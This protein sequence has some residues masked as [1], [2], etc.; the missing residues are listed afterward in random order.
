MS[1]LASMPKDLGKPS[2]QAERV[3]N[4]DQ[5]LT[6]PGHQ[7]AQEETRCFFVPAWSVFFVFPYPHIG[8]DRNFVRTLCK[9]RGA[10]RLVGG[11]H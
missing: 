1:P 9:A 7:L 6:T 11:R 2:S 3:Q 5:D 8:A 4:A 10:V